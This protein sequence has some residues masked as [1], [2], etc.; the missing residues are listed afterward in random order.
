MGRFVFWLSH[1]EPESAQMT[2]FQGL[3]TDNG[4]SA[5]IA[6]FGMTPPPVGDRQ[7]AYRAMLLELANALKATAEGPA[8]DFSEQ[9][10]STS[11]SRYGLTPRTTPRVRAEAGHVIVRL[12]S[13]SLRDRTDVLD[14]ELVLPPEIAGPLGLD[15][16]DAT[17]NVKG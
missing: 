3:F 10:N 2:G 13:A 5:Q 16:L 14:I 9:S 7:S 12:E 1:R 11:A 8:G 15:L 6:A 17:Q 4:I